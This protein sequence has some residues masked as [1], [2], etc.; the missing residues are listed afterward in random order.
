M[1]LSSTP[2]SVVYLN[3]SSVCTKIPWFSPLM[4]MAIDPY[5][6]NCMSHFISQSLHSFTK[7]ATQNLVQ[8]MLF[9]YQCCFKSSRPRS[10]GIIHD[11]SKRIGKMLPISKNK[12]LPAGNCCLPGLSGCHASSLCWV[13]LFFPIGTMPSSKP[14]SLCFPEAPGFCPH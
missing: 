6:F 11:A 3:L 5:A 12:Q 2:S 8:W 7:V 1:P 10:S 4:L 13:P 14:F 9:W